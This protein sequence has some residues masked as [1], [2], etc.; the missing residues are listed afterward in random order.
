M[1]TEHPKFMAL[2]VEESLKIRVLWTLAVGNAP[3]S[4]FAF[5]YGLAAFR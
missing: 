3:R 4:W 1:S 5:D 2:A